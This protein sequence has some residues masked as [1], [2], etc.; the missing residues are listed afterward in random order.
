[1]RRLKILVAEKDDLLR[2]KTAGVLSRFE[3]VSMVAQTS[4]SKELLGIIDEINPDIFLID[5]VMASN[6]RK[7]IKDVITFRPGLRIFLTAGEIDP[8]TENLSVYFG[9]V[10]VI[11]KD[12]IIS[13]MKQKGALNAAEKIDDPILERRELCVLL[14]DDDAF[15]RQIMEHMLSK[16]HIGHKAVVSGEQAYMEVVSFPDK[17]GCLVLDV[18][19]NSIDGF[20]VGRMIR[21]I[22]KGIPIVFV[23][24]DDSKETESKAEKMGRSI[25]LKKPF[26]NETL[27]EAIKK[28]IA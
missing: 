22:S 14:V 19:M 26:R 2:E 25:F 16:A 7:M 3:D 17:Y 5:A 21:D 6:N 27:I 24:S 15:Y 4:D 12:R 1:M 10:A 28:S 23:T 13:E 18:H 11:R 8:F 20:T 9:N